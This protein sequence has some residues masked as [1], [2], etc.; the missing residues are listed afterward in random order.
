[1]LIDAA[2]IRGGM[3][4]MRW[5][6]ARPR[7]RTHWHV[8]SALLALSL[9]GLALVPRGVVGERG[10]LAAEV[11]E[12]WKELHAHQLT[13]PAAAHS[14]VDDAVHA[15]LEKVRTDS[16]LPASLI[17][18]LHDVD[19]AGRTVLH[20]AVVFDDPGSVDAIVAAGADLEAVDTALSTPL[21]IAAAQGCPRAIRALLGHGANATAR[22]VYQRTPLHRAALAGELASAKALL[23]APPPT[24]SSKKTQKGRAPATPPK[25]DKG[26]G[27]GSAAAQLNAKDVDGVT[28][29]A[30]AAAGA[31]NAGAV[32]RA[33]LSAGADPASRDVYGSTPLHRAA[34]TGAIKVVEA[35]VAAEE[36]KNDGGATGR[37]LEPPDEQGRTPLHDAAFA[38]QQRVVAA[39]V[40]AGA[41]PVTPDHAGNTALH[42]AAGGGHPAVAT[43]L[44]TAGGLELGQAK[45]AAGETAADIA[46]AAGHAA[47]AQE[48]QAGVI[49]AAARRWLLA[50]FETHDPGRVAEVEGLLQEHAGREA[51]LIREVES[52][53]NAE[54]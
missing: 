46:A 52:R 39:L 9:A 31:R 19:S 16:P 2:L 36:K 35:L 45:N 33:L 23:S 53:Y 6:H 7:S 11:A 10:K 3:A 5:H 12:K 20:Y 13:D 37:Q 42:A 41:S 47:T 21:H 34:A 51:E 29:L 50:F 30:A 48:I 1:M 28:A 8:F 15:I 14:L 49:T 18:K 17:A 44:L 38:G 25:G 4:E 26:S 24:P 43:A 22:D 32:A 54:L 27:K 40:A